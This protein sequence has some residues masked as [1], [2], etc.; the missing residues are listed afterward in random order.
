[1]EQPLGSHQSYF[2]HLFM[3][4]LQ[5]RPS[6]IQEY[7]KGML[8]TH[9]P[10]KIQNVGL[11]CYNTSTP[12]TLTYSSLQRTL[13][14]MDMYPFWAPL[15]HVDQTTI[16]HNLSAKYSVLNTLTHRARTVSTNPQL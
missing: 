12:W 11:N 10:S 15:L 8:M 14:Q 13:T 1:M 3:E 9:L 16:T 4:E 6:T 7:E 2:G 5:T